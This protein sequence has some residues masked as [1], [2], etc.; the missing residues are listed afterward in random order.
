MIGFYATNS[1]WSFIL[2]RPD[3]ELGLDGKAFDRNILS[4]IP[5]GAA[6]WCKPFTDVLQFGYDVYVPRDIRMEYLG[7][8]E[9]GNVDE[10]YHDGEYKQS[11][12]LDNFQLPEIV[13][14]GAPTDRNCTIYTGLTIKC[15][16][17]YGFM[18]MPHPVFKSKHW[19]IDS[20]F[21]RGGEVTY[22]Y[23]LNLRA[24]SK[25]IIH[26]KH[27]EPIARLV[28]LKVADVEKKHETIVSSLDKNP[29][30]LQELSTYLKLK[31]S[32]DPHAGLKDHNIYRKMIKFFHK[33]GKCPFHVSDMNK[34]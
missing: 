30:L 25:G 14:R 34:A 19:T 32:S 11:S 8:G 2:K 31:Y 12:Y 4:D 17:D 16:S 6:M 5:H 22:H 15:D 18:W 13:T 29:K 20:G 9:W 26:L 33:T 27:N 10:F 28:L 23:W 3:T 1:Y 7:D 24:M 21:V